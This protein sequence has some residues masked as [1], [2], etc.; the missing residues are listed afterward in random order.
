MINS[1]AVHLKDSFP[2]ILHASDGSPTLLHLLTLP[3]KRIV[4]SSPH[5]SL[6]APHPPPK[7]PHLT[8]RCRISVRDR[9][10]LL[11]ILMSS[12]SSDVVYSFSCSMLRAQF[13]R[14]CSRSTCRVCGAT[15]GGFRSFPGYQNHSV[16]GATASPAAAPSSLLPTTMDS[17]VIAQARQPSYWQPWDQPFT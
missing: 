7:S 4:S 15:A 6:K 8:D 16:R 3:P 17:Y 10:M 14:L 2:P 5:M 9:R 1:P 13:L 11:A 12:F